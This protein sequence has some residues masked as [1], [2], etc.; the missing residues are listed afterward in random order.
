[1]VGGPQPV[2]PNSSTRMPRIPIGL[3]RPTPAH[4]PLGPVVLF[5]SPT[6]VLPRSLPG[7]SSQGLGVSTRVSL[8]FFPHPPSH[9]HVELAVSV[10]TFWP[11]QGKG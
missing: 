10:S 6:H 2:S 5:P 11:E 8:P 4:Q 9:P 3:V 1:M 7:P